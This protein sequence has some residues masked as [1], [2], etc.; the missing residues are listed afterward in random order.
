MSPSRLRLLFG[1]LAAFF[2]GLGIVAGIM[3]VRED[4]LV[5]RVVA[6]ARAS[7]PHEEGSED[8]V[9][10]IMSYVHR[11]L[12]PRLDSI[13]QVEDFVPGWLRSTDAQLQQPSGH[14]GSF[15][16]VCARALQRAG[17]SVRIGQMLVGKTWGGHIVVLVS[18]GGREVVLDPKYDLAFR[19]PDRR[20]LTWPEVQRAWDS[21]SDQRPPEY[22]PRYRYEGMRYTNWRGLPVELLGNWAREISV[23]TYLLN[24]YWVWFWLLC[25]L[26][27]ISA[28]CF[29]WTVRRQRRGPARPHYRTR[30]AVYSALVR[31]QR[32]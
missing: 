6:G 10:S 22:D 23:R 8:D 7:N 25:V 3:A 27:V 31:A 30:M 19:G 11:L 13:A 24:L 17:Y 26:S 9:T 14:C 28:I 32:P 2:C 20:L 15:V 4:A 1:L 12:Q 5:D 29:I 18:V 16:H 21:L